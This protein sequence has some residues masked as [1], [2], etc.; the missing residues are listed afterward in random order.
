ML[1]KDNPIIRVSDLNESVEI[2]VARSLDRLIGVGY[3]GRGR[4]SVNRKK[5]AKTHGKNKRKRK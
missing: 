1:N 2:T 5:K 3:P 4:P